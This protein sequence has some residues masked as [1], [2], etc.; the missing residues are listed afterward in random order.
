MPF[1]TMIDVYPINSYAACAK[2]PSKLVAP[3]GDIPTDILVLTIGGI[4]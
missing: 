4:L 1:S 2:Q 3:K